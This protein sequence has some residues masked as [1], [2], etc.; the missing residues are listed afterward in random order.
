MLLR[1]E[2]VS[3]SFGGVQAVDGAS[4]AVRQGDIHGL[5][6]PNGAGKTTLLNMVSGLIPL[7][8]GSI[9]LADRKIDRLPPHRIAALGV[10]RT[11]QNIRL[12][13]ELSALS[14]VIVGEHLRRKDTFLESLLFMP[15]A[16]HEHEVARERARALLARVGL[17]E[18]AEERAANLSYG[19]QRRV[20]IARALAAD[21]AVLLLDEPTAG[22]NPAEVTAVGRLVA[23]VASQGHTVLLI[24]HNVKLVMSICRTVT[25]LDFGKV[26]AEGPPAAIASDP[27]VIAAYLG[28]KP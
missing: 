20:E 11:Y 10:A 28:A 2:R 13:P 9:F 23:E 27:A 25:V 21:P 3:R 16:R 6:G 24:E 8:S 4:F 22:M 17:L 15:S 18:R 12:F 26:I 19:E 5:I 7:T 14:N 1:L